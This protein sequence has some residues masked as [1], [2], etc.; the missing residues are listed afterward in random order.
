MRSPIAAG[1]L[2]R[3]LAADLA[4]GGPQVPDQATSFPT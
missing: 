1:A 3:M 2:A 4:V